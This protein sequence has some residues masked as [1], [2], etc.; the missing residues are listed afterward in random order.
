MGE[1][2]FKRAEIPLPLTVKPARDRVPLEECGEPLV[3]SS[4]SPDKILVRSWYHQ[5]GLKGSLPECFVRE[6]VYEK[7][8][9][10]ARRLPEKW[11]LVIWDG[12]RRPELQKSFF[13][14]LED[15]IKAAHPDLSPEELK[16]RTSIFVAWPSTDPENVSGHCTGGA[17][18]LTIADDRGRYLEMGSGFDEPTERSYTNHYEKMERLEGAA[19]QARDNRRILVSLMSE[20]GFSNYPNEWW[21]FD[22]GNRK[23]A[24]RTG[25]PKA[26]YGYTEPPFRWQ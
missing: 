17:V 13:S 3:P 23:W 16:R 8:L 7:L 21:H 20:E 19:L 9:L 6:S 11:H 22:Y 25:A 15:R 12:W 24:L 10:V 2:F 5:E 1:N 4:L 14:T 26:I 18:D